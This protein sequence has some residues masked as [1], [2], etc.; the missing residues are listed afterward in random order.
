M[1]STAG[2]RRR[3]EIGM[4]GAAATFQRDFRKQANVMRVRA[5]QRGTEVRKCL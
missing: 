5:A 3:L 1:L 4:K 2:Q